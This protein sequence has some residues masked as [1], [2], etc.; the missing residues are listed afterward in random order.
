M[1]VCDEYCFMGLRLNRGIGLRI[2]F[3][4]KSLLLLH[5]HFFW[6]WRSCGQMLHRSICVERSLI[7]GRMAMLVV[8]EIVDNNDVGGSIAML[9]VS[10]VFGNSNVSEKH[11][12]SR[13]EVSQ[14]CSAREGTRVRNAP[15][16]TIKN[17]FRD[18]AESLWESRDKT[19]IFGSFCRG[20]RGGA[21]RGK[22][23][24]R[25]PTSA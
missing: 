16:V 25:P 8:S 7:S 22:L 17:E 6:F 2:V 23:P 11:Q 4:T 1:F 13:C 24:S 10:E 3:N 14:I 20:V 18:F 15:C 5:L 9:A 21:F 19:S 12:N